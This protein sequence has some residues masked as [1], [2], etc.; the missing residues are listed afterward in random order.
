[1]SLVI[2]CNETNDLYCALMS[3]GVA[4]ARYNTPRDAIE[5]AP[6]GAGVAILADGYPGR[7]TEC[8]P[9]LCEAAAQRRLRLYVEY[10]TQLPGM[11][12]GEPRGT[13]WERAVISSDVFAP[14]LERLRILAIQSCR[15]TPVTAENSHIVM[16]RVAG[17]DRAVYGLPEERYPILTVCQATTNCV[18]HPAGRIL[19]ATTKLS[20][21]VTARYAPTDAWRSIW[22]YILK[23][24]TGQSLELDWTPTVRP[25]FGRN[26]ELPAD[27]E[28]QALR[29][30]AQWYFRAKLLP[31][32]P[33]GEIGDGRDQAAR[34]GKPRE[35]DWP[36]GDG[37]CGLLEGF[38]ATIDYDG[39][40][41]LQWSRRNDCMGEAAMALAFDGVINNDPHS[42]GVARNLNDFVY[43]ASI[44]TKGPRNDPESPSFGLL[45]WDVHHSPGVFYGDDTARSVLSVLA[46]AALL[47]T[48]RWDEKILRCLLANLRTTGRLGFRGER[49]DEG[50]LHENGWRHYYENDTIH[51]AP[52]FESFLWACFLWAYRRTGYGLFLDRPKSG[53]RRT[54]EAYPDGWRWTNGLQQERA[55][56]LLSLSWLVRVED[57]PEHREWLRFMANELLKHQAQCGA[58]REE[59]GPEG[60]GTFGPPKSNEEYGVAEA[61]LIQTN[62]DPLCDLLYTT[63]FA[64][65]GLHE[66][67][68][69]TGDSFYVEAEE[70]LAKF[71][72]RIQICSERHPNLDGAWFR[73][74]DYNRWE[75]WA[76]SAD[77]GWGAWS[78]ESGWTCGWIN[79][80]LAMRRVKTS[81]WDLTSGS[82]IEKHMKALEPLMF[83][84][85]ECIDS[86]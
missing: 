50:P 70:R 2:A 76:S 36:V 45:G 43:L 27:I 6:V 78:I 86:C 11:D 82:T 57:T 68:A 17:F 58:I 55:R 14:G 75:Y 28:A 51:C 33:W 71:L 41:S 4:V 25:S 18:E 59:L 31:A 29:R 35:E 9:S 48:D 84:N 63:N 19:V 15:F 3:A 37:S 80:V 23:W 8:D 42:C 20:L 74:F 67:A 39:S 44:A 10:P 65:L 64:F 83:K 40:Q 7:Q 85:T 52:H 34:F 56:M 47:D 1:M 13:K 32:P 12:V 24:L 5:Q 22:A 38:S 60:K 72:C 30:G 73:A 69:A 53:I 61:P 66:A 46:C 77:I 26:E 79:A 81:L 21:F 49:I 54:M 16:A 62:G